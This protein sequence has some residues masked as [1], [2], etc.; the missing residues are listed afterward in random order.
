MN[1]I[2]DQMLEATEN[3]IPNTFLEKVI[4]FTTTDVDSSLEYMNAN[5]FNSGGHIFANLKDSYKYLW[6]AYSHGEVKTSTMKQFFND[7][8]IQGINSFKS[9]FVKNPLGLLFQLNLHFR[10]S[11]T[12]SAASGICSLAFN[13]F[14]A[15]EQAALSL[16]QLPSL[17]NSL[18]VLANGIVSSIDNIVEGEIQKLENV[19]SAFESLLQNGTIP[20]SIIAMFDQMVTDT[21]MMFSKSNI[22]QIKKDIQNGIAELAHSFE[23]LDANKLFYIQSLFCSTITSLENILQNPVSALNLFAGRSKEQIVGINNSCSDSN[24]VNHA[25]GRIVYNQD[26]I[27]NI[28]NEWKN[29]Y[30]NSYI[31]F[32]ERFLP[33][34]KYTRTAHRSPSSWKYLSFTGDVLD[35]IDMGDHLPKDVGYWKT[36]LKVLLMLNQVGKELN[37]KL[38][39]SSAYRPPLYNKALSGSAKRSFHMR[40]TA[41]DVHWPFVNKKQN[42]KFIRLCMQEG[43]SGFGY[44]KPF[45]HLDIGPARSWGDPYIVWDKSNFPGHP[46][47]KQYAPVRPLSH[48]VR[49]GYQNS[50]L[51]PTQ[52]ESIIRQESNVRGID[53]NVA[54]AIYTHEGLS[55]YQSQFTSPTGVGLERS[56]GPFQL[57]MGGGVGNQFYKDTGIDPSSDRSKSSIT[58]QIRYALDYASR[59]GWGAWSGHIRAKV[60]VREGLSNSK[61]VG[62]K[63]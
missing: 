52:I 41:L 6:E 49:P 37:T 25:A 59:N 7:Y 34:L 11:T 62:W 27:K 55:N 43:F 23:N 45:V 18:S 15:I 54:I 8:S 42:Q 12:N 35:M 53:P 63:S 2:T 24:R 29:S 32:G 5:I 30:N 38:T 56:F 44:Y 60:G 47:H 16:S 17:A 14:A 19:A 58:T 9:M 51:T 3:I 33:S 31:P 4:S 39:V 20:H 50:E 36:S 26:K 61:A 57:Y 1:Y 48:N 28:Q 46:P 40:G 21:K 10:P 13:P 22:D